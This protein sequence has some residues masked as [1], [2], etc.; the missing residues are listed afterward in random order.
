MANYQIFPAN[1]PCI[2]WDCPALALWR[3]TRSSDLGSGQW[4]MFRVNL[5]HLKRGFLRTVVYVSFF[6]LFHNNWQCIGSNFSVNREPEAENSIYLKWTW[7]L[8]EPLYWPQRCSGTSFLSH[9][10]TVSSIDSFRSYW[11]SAYK[12]SWDPVIKLARENLYESL[13]VW[14][15]TGKQTAKS[16]SIV[17]SIT[18]RMNRERGQGKLWWGSWRFPCLRSWSVTRFLGPLKIHSHLNIWGKNFQE[19]EMCNGLEART[20]LAW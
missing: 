11:W 18:K 5:C 17:I 16:F 12:V 19:R 9:W 7:D 13:C 20:S 2:W 8:K 3:L 6:S 15:K 10:Y 14:R 4:E 1:F